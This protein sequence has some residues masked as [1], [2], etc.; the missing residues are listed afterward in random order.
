MTDMTTTANLHSLTTGSAVEGSYMGTPF[1]GTVISARLHTMNHNL[2]VIH[3]ALPEGWS[4]R[5]VVRTSICLDV[6]TETGTDKYGS[7]IIATKVEPCFFC[8]QPEV[9]GHVCPPA[10]TARLVAERLRAARA[11]R[12]ALRVSLANKY[13]N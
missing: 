12:S 7:Q 10:T 8:G 11:R 6:D 5:G 13:G 4:Y 1:T 9:P 3:I 2:Y